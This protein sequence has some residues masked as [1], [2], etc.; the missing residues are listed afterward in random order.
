VTQLDTLPGLRATGTFGGLYP[1]EAEFA[2]AHGLVRP[3]GFGYLTR[4]GT[5][6]IRS[7]RAFR[8]DP[9]C[10]YRALHFGD[11]QWAA[12]AEH[13]SKYGIPFHYLLH[14]P[15]HM[16]SETVVPVQL[17]LPE[18]PIPAV[19]TCVMPGRA[20]QIRDNRPHS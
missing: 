8:F 15:G 9:E 2:E 19:G 1:R 6:D 7:P 14:H 13:E 10:C 20:G 3:G 16:P 11:K 4:P 18:R 5:T 12:I 17:P